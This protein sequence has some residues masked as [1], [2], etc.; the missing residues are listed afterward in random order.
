MAHG[1]AIPGFRDPID[2]DK[3]RTRIPT[4]KIY[5]QKPI[6]E[7]VKEAR[8]KVKSPSPITYH[9]EEAI[10]KTRSPRQ[11]KYQF[12]KSERKSNLDKMLEK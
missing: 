2:L 11:P 7:L 9:K 5:A 3:I 8:N 6:P 12:P 4:T 1:Q 10:D